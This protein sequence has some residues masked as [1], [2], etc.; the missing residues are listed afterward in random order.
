MFF[1]IRI[2]QSLG[3]LRIAF[4]IIV[5]YLSFF[6]RPFYLLSSYIAFNKLRIH[7]YTKRIMYINHGC[8]RRG[9][10]D[11]INNANSK[12]HRCE[13]RSQ[14][15]LIVPPPPVALVVLFLLQS[16]LSV[17]HEEMAGL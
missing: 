10:C 11:R 1:R 17:L 12:K 6:F 15:G 13:L 2:A 8:G 9:G 3:F 4:Q 7:N 5:C 16:Q 14:E